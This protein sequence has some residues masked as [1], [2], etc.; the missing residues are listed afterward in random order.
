MSTRTST[1]PVDT[2]SDQPVYRWDGEF[3]DRTLEARFVNDTWGEVVARSRA[4][5]LAGLVFMIAAGV[6]YITL[7]YSQ[8]FFQLLALRLL[9]L[10]VAFV[11]VVLF[12][13]GRDPKAFYASVTF[14]QVYLFTVFLMSSIV[15]TSPVRD[16]A[17]ATIVIL[18][19]YYIAVPNRLHLN[20]MVGIL[21]SA[22]LI[23]TTSFTPDISLYG[24]GVLSVMCVTVNFV[25]IQLGRLWGRLRRTE[26]LSMEHH[27]TMAGRLAEE[28]A[29]R[30]VAETEARANERSFEG[31]FRAAPLPLVLV[32]PGETKIQLGNRAACDLLGVR[33]EEMKNLDLQKVIEAR[34]VE[35]RFEDVKT[36]L[37][38]REPAEIAIESADG[39]HLWVNVTTSAMRYRGAPTILIALHD[40]THRREEEERLRD[41][42]DV[43][44][45]ANRS[46]TEF[47]A[48]MSHELR[49]PLNAIIGFSEAL[50]REIYGELGNDRY[51]EYAQDIHSSGIHLLNIIN[52]I[53]DL[54]KI[55]AD[56]FE[57]AE[58]TV[59]IEETIDTVMRIVAPRA[60]Q[61]G[62]K[63]E[64][65][66]TDGLGV[67]CDERAVKQILIN[68]LSNAVKFSRE[69]TTVRVDVSETE[70]SLRIAV[71][72]Q[73]IGMAPE[74]IPEALEPFRQI[75]GTLTRT[76][77]GTG[78]GLPLAR[79]LTELHG[80]KLT[81]ESAR[82][83]GTS[84]F[85]DLPLARIDAPA[86]EKEP[87]TVSA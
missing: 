66:V 40:I 21:C 68:L 87:E 67:C 12:S 9:T 39:R 45:S 82:G 7:G 41:A 69:K 52:D 77:E 23:F 59:S 22:G 71:V 57:L 29:E 84:V 36:F 34:M 53:L 6:D 13:D 14:T 70:T 18:F 50:D 85:I 46:K 31:V 86:D 81:I 15:G 49:T 16:M 75:D 55:E 72:D 78:L 5:M 54:S 27:K 73:G 47:L 51:K 1:Q 74:D 28:I 8:A 80:G 44:D 64:K 42:R 17:V 43:A 58:E 63:L 11:P 30:Q 61:A 19:T 32:H 26:H 38:A 62:V 3:A 48:N 65:S 35:N 33:P 2:N 76:Y 10:I 60:D 37:N 56:K 24:L 25:G 79:R 4:V 20:A 83:E